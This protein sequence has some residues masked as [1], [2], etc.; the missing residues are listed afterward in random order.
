MSCTRGA[1]KTSCRRA[2]AFTAANFFLS[3]LNRANRASRL[4]PSFIAEAIRNGA[5]GYKVK[6]DSKVVPL[7]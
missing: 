5:P 3:R 2:R 4:A 1:A 6:D 7:R